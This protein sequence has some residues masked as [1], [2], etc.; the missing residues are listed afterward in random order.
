MLRFVLDRTA[1]PYFSNLVWFM[2]DQS[3]SLN[4]HIMRHGGTLSPSALS[5]LKD[6]VA[7]HLDNLF[8][9]NDIL[10]LNVHA[11]NEVL[12]AQVIKKL[13]IPLYVH[14]LVPPYALQIGEQVQPSPHPPHCPRP[15]ASPTPTYTHAPDAEGTILKKCVCVHVCVCM[16]GV[17]VCVCKLCKCV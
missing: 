2:S 17:C 16:C 8:Y 3:L 4:E 10:C 7:E 13:L 14:S 15:V 12:T 6:M 11:I 1:V 5:K 9:L